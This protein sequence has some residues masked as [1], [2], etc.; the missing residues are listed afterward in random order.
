MAD[1]L[2]FENTQ[3]VTSVENLSEEEQD[4]LRVGEALQEQQNELLAG[5][6]KDAQELER[7]YVE[8]EKKLGSPKEEAAKA[9]SETEPEAKQEEDKPAQ[10]NILE[11][12]WQEAT[13]GDKYSDETLNTSPVLGLI[14]FRIVVCNETSLIHLLESV[15]ALVKFCD[16]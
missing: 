5:K 10:T 8:L 15:I 3:E 11:T 13:T 7:A 16:L 4:S 12:L 6:Y 1:T 9:E 2:T 14:Y